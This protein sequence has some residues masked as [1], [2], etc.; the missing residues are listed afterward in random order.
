MTY[1]ILVITDA[2]FAA[3]GYG[4]QADKVFSELVKRGYDVYQFACN[5]FTTGN[6][7]YDEDGF[8]IHNGIKCI[9]N[10]KIWENPKDIYPTAQDVRWWFDSIKPDIVFSLNDFYRVDDYLSLGNDFVSKWVHWLPIDNDMPDE[11]WPSRERNMK[12]LVYLT[13]F[14]MEKDGS[15]VG[16]IHYMDYIYHAIPNDVFKPVV[17]KQELKRVHGIANTF[18]VT[19]VGKHQPRKMIYHTAHAV[20][21]FLQTHKDAI[22][23]CKTNPK[24]GCML[25]EPESERDL[26]GLV[27]SYGVE[28]Q[29][30]FEPYNL[31]NDQMNNL[32]NLGDVFISLTGGEG[33]NIPIVE[34]MLAGVPC[35]LTNSTTA[36]ELTNNWEFAFPV[37]VEMKKFVNAFNVGYDIA[38]LTEAV[39][40]LNHAYNDWKDNGSAGLHEYGKKARDFHVRHCS[41]KEVCDEWEEVFKRIIRYN[42]KLVWHTFFGRGTGLSNIGEY[43]IPR[44][45]E[46]G[47]DVYANDW[48]SGTSV[49]L[50]DHIRELYNKYKKN[51]NKINFEEH[52]QVLSWLMESYPYIKGNWK[53]GFSFVESTRL[54]EYYMRHTNMMDYLI[55]SCEHNREVQRKSGVV[56]PIR[57]IP[58][59]VNEDIFKYIDRKH[60]GKPFTFLHIGVIQERKNTAQ[61]IEGYLRAFEDDGRTKLIIKSGDF[62]ILEKIKPICAGRNDIE[63]LY[64]SDKPMTTSEMLGL[65]ERADCY[66]NLSHGEGIGMPDLEAMATGLPVI[67]ANWDARGAFL[68]NSVGWMVNVSFFAK[69]YRSGVE[70]DC[71][72]WAH[73]DG[74][75]YVKILRYVFDNQDEARN[76]GKLA[77][78][79]VANNFNSKIAANAMDDIL[80]EVYNKKKTTQKTVY[81]ENY[82]T[83]VHKYTPEWHEGVASAI[84]QK[85]YG[86]NGK[87]IDV[88]CG[89][90]YL[91]KHFLSKGKDVVGIEISDYA[92]E[93]PIEGCEGKIFKAS[94]TDI[95]YTDEYFDWAV[96]F[97]V[98]EHLP[99]S[100]IQDSLRELKRVAKNIYMEIAMPMY[101]GHEKEIEA[102]DSTHIT[103]R[104]MEWWKQQFYKAGL[105]IEWNH[106]MEMILK[107]IEYIPKAVEYGD[108]VLVGIPTKDR[109]KS[110]TRLLDTIAMQTYKNLDVVIV[111]DSIKDR[112]I[113]SKEFND[114]VNNLY[115]LGMNVMVVRG[116]GHNQVYAHNQILEHAVNND[117]KLVFRLDDDIFL[118]AEHIDNIVKEFVKDKNCEYAAMGGVFTNPFVSLEQQRLPDNWKNDRL[119]AGSIRECVPHAQ[120]VL[121]PPEIETRDDIEHL[122]SSYIYRPELLLKVGGFPA[123]LSKVGFREETLPIY[124]LKLMG[125]KLKIVTKSIGAHYHE[126]SGGC[127]SQEYANPGEMYSS[128]ENVFRRRVAELESKYSK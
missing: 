121:Y 12:F 96:C 2:P 103:V 36:P 20:C 95:P 94:I 43:M 58:P 122:Y 14:G 46:M 64:T 72:E 26:E 73:Y 55:T 57:I 91:M 124:E 5:Y 111:D 50:D 34:S 127:R 54:R 106:G 22:W 97:S 11:M 51:E 10:K 3:T 68:D 39:A 65:Y 16:K 117:Y 60:E 69:A 110:L 31:S 120:I 84:I 93:H 109:C 105:K 67:G 56:A 24:D 79:R 98:M 4:N 47:Y 18:V 102:E 108:R 25:N 17:D 104:H 119:F 42:N 52:P 30:A 53:I 37:S 85:T 75:H 113:E 38:N 21:R 126:P 27:K 100:I 86:L 76:K 9:V 66:I 62:G 40:Q 6:E 1:K 23:I 44:L 116:S 71:G 114:R 33:F 81:D 87:V 59:F 48:N 125:Y 49:V 123:E 63:M 19:T 89:R 88:G 99:E 112:L 118:K 32:Y 61:L 70:E 82:Y 90:G 13:K 28:S 15:R 41:V 74:E 45:E 7:V 115:V 92:V 80:F 107:P 83:N 78:E 128:D 77:A 101:P 35:I 8:L 29:V